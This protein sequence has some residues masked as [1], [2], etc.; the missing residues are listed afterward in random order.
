MADYFDTIN[1]KSELQQLFG[2]FNIDELC[3][4]DNTVSIN[5]EYSTKVNTN[6]NNDT[7]QSLTERFTTEYDNI[8]NDLRHDIQ[9]G[10]KMFKPIFTEDF[11]YDDLIEKTTVSTR[12]TLS[13]KKLIISTLNMTVELDIFKYF[14]NDNFIDFD[15]SL[16]RKCLNILFVY[17][18][19]RLLCISPNTVAV[20][21]CINTQIQ[22]SVKSTDVKMTTLALFRTYYL[23]YLKI[24]ITDT[25]CNDFINY[26]NSLS[27]KQQIIVYEFC[28]I[29]IYGLI[30][31]NY[32]CTECIDCRG[33][34]YCRECIDCDL[35]I[36]CVK[37]SGNIFTIH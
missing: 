18:E 7:L 33:C 9:L 22:S 16:K 12:N 15:D 17:P 2:D 4:V 21:K 30:P 36:N 25:S 27:I 34:V 5:Q 19:Y 37:C 29:M 8:S 32:L 14:C 6:H 3:L 26:V 20:N 1:D 10:S 31:K 35:C 13:M 11:W 28:V 24:L 23:R